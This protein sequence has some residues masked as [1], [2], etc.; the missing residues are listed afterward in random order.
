MRVTKVGADLPQRARP[1]SRVRMRVFGFQPG[2]TV[3]L[4]VRRGGRT[5]GTFR[6]GV[7]AAPCGTAARRLRYMPLRRWSTGSYTYEFQQSKRF[8][9]KKPRVQ[10]RVSLFRSAATR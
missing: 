10:L 2:R 4:H 9:R 3:F 5:R 8:D 1:T 7:P 6:I